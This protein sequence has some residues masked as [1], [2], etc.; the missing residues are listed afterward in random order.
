MF[1]RLK[2]KLREHRVL[3]QCGCFI[4]CLKCNEIQNDSAECKRIDANRY[5]YTCSKCGNVAIALYGVF[6]LP[7]W[8]SMVIQ[9]QKKI[10]DLTTKLERPKQ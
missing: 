9:T 6:P 8:E 10:S 7:V 5:E 1:N 2:Q 3:R 4:K